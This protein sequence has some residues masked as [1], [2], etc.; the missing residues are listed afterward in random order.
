MLEANL[1]LALRVGTGLTS[2]SSRFQLLAG[3]AVQGP[4]TSWS[5]GWSGNSDSLMHQKI[6][7]VHDSVLE[8]LPV[9][10]EVAAHWGE[11][12]G[13]SK[14]DQDCSL[15]QNRQASVVSQGPANR[16]ADCIPD[17]DGF[18]RKKPVTG[19]V[20]FCLPDGPLRPS[21]GHVGP[22]ALPVTFSLEDSLGL[23]KKVP[24]VAAGWWWGVWCKQR[25]QRVCV[26]RTPWRCP[27]PLSVSFFEPWS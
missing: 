10:L 2:Q 3:V 7:E 26:R 20:L 5:R 14:L 1:D 6:L 24:A 25:A 27:R 4:W 16:R 13:G 8:Q 19:W 22:S 15:M 18:S 23:R 17:G 11:G 12:S 9:F 21:P